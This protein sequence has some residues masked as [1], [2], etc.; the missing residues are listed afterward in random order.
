MQEK[1][2]EKEKKLRA[3]MEKCFVAS[4]ALEF[5][6]TACQF[7]QLFQSY[8]NDKN[9]N[10]QYKNVCSNLPAVIW[11]H[12]FSFVSYQDMMKGYA[13]NK[14]LNHVLSSS[15]NPNRVIKGLNSEGIKLKKK[16]SK[17]FLKYVFLSGKNY[18]RLI[19][20]FPLNNKNNN[21]NNKIFEPFF[22]K[23]LEMERLG[24]KVTEILSVTPTLMVVRCWIKKKRKIFIWFFNSKVPQLIHLSKDVLPEGRFMANEKY[25]VHNFQG[26]LFVYN[27]QGDWIQT[28]KN[29]KYVNNDKVALALTNQF[30]VSCHTTWESD[31]KSDVTTTD[32][33]HITDDIKTPLFNFSSLIDKN[34]KGEYYTIGLD[35]RF[36]YYITDRGEFIVRLLEYPHSVLVTQTTTTFIPPSTPWS[37]DE[38]VFGKHGLYWNGRK[39]IKNSKWSKHTIFFPFKF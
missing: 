22:Q 24:S 16:K 34:H 32:F 37:N 33:F 7:N 20:T 8:Q 28:Y 39:K 9:Q 31:S 14:N 11:I 3:C 5:S 23:S 17:Y 4:N 25:L 2:T 15:S 13:V 29:I 36:F 6:D 21:S 1:V 12:I 10:P 38:Q 27:F 30:L 18:W 35:N 19:S 26:N